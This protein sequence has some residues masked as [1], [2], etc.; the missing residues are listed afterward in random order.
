MNSA[1][2]SKEALF[3]LYSGILSEKATKPPGYLA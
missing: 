1:G 3:S 2:F